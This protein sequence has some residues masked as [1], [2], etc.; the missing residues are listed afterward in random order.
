M[1]ARS[2]EKFFGILGDQFLRMGVFYVLS[3]VLAAGIKTFKL[4][5]KI[6]H[7]LSRAGAWS[8]PLATAAGLI[9]P[10]CSC[11]VLPIVASLMAAGCRYARLFSLQ[12]Q[13]YL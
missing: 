4:D 8:I 12:A 11:G 7:A 2:M 6:R 5:K 13:G 9:S 10:L 3:V 1:M